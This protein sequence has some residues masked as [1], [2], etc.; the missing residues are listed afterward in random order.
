MHSYYL[1]Q[2]CGRFLFLILI[3]L[4]ISSSAIP[5]TAVVSTPTKFDSTEYIFIGKVINYLGPLQP[6]SLHRDY[7]SLL[8]EIVDPIYLPKTPMKYFEIIYYDLTPDCQL[9]PWDLGT[10]QRLFP[11]NSYIRVVAKDSKYMTRNVNPGNIRLDLDPFNNFQISIDYPDI[12][13]LHSSHD[14]KYDY[15]YMFE[16]SSAKF[17]SSNKWITEKNKD[18]YH[19]SYWWLGEFEL[20]KD[21][22]R[23]AL[24]KNIDQKVEIL[25]RLSH[26]P[27]FDQTT[28]NKIVPSYIDNPKL[29][30]QIIN[31]YT[32]LKKPIPSDTTLHSELPASLKAKWVHTGGPSGG[33][34]NLLKLITS[35]SGIKYLFAGASDNELYRSSDNGKNWIKITIGSIHNN[36]AAFFS[37]NNYL[38]VGTGEGVFRSSDDGLRWDSLNTG[39]SIKEKSR[40][41]CFTSNSK[42]IFAGADTKGI[43]RSSDE[44]NSWTIVNPAVNQQQVW[45]LC[46]KGPLLFAGTT[47]GIY[48][49]SD[50]GDKWLA[51]NNG[52]PTNLRYPNGMFRLPVANIVY[53]NGKLFA[54]LDGEGL[55]LSSDN[56]ISWKV[57]DAKFH[58][59]RIFRMI[60]DSENLFLSSDGQ[61]FLSRDTGATWTP[62]NIEP[63]NRCIISAVDHSN[64]YACSSNGIFFSSDF[65]RNW[66]VSNKGLSKTYISKLTVKGNTLFAATGSGLFKSIDNG[67]NWDFISQNILNFEITDIAVNEKYLVVGSIRGIY[68]SSD[69]GDTWI[70]KFEKENI[71]ALLVKGNLILAQT[72][73]GIC[74]STDN[75]TNWTT[76]KRFRALSK[77]TE[78]G[79]CLFA[80]R[81]DKLL[82]STDEGITWDTA[83]VPVKNFDLESMIDDGKNLY[84]TISSSRSLFLST[85]KGAD[86]TIIKKE[87]GFYVQTLLASEK[88]FFAADRDHGVSISTNKGIKWIP[89]N[90]GL[91]NLR[92][93]TLIVK[94]NILFAGTTNGVWMHSL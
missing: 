12:P 52:L 76:D 15:R 50:N 42:F 66:I 81:V 87:D 18:N 60:G 21:L 40:I 53:I 54:G 16:D 72:N 57:S 92:V 65:G 80:K 2:F 17:L 6:D 86:W 36:V 75:G 70:V 73:L 64:L 89:F 1:K 43:F 28:S 67:K 71:N 7:N 82:R 68:L 78:C 91:G 69:Y 58:Y 59:F 47:V 5:C 24:L 31:L 49:S 27:H 33:D 44:G 88:Y 83:K 74:R 14:S 61:V 9:I 32:P 46:A 11:L 77:F 79:G 19:N 10:I 35:R 13:Q 56:G 45:A 63:I 55:F 94:D 22:Y 3:L 34:F 85:N 84:S 30:E 26:Y 37:H 4:F 39:F 38:F 20:R 25:K 62:F 93:Y 8:V 90:Y 29:R 51:S 23:L 48:V 41:N